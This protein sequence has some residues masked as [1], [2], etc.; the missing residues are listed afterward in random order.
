MR[1]ALNDARGSDQSARGRCADATVIRPGAT[2]ARIETLRRRGFG[3]DAMPCYSNGWSIAGLCGR[4]ATVA[5]RHGGLVDLHAR[6][7]LLGASA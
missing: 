6:K 1:R 7:S 4:L 3:S 5:S 2:E